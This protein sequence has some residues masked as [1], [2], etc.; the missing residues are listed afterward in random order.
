MNINAQQVILRHTCQT[1]Q[2][3]IKFNL[4]YGS[5]DFAMH[6]VATKRKQIRFNINLNCLT[7]MHLILK[8]TCCA[9]IF[10]LSLFIFLEIDCFH[11]QWT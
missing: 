5:D 2:I 9:F 4:L 3:Y 10:I 6:H 11:S 1:I 8:I 7:C